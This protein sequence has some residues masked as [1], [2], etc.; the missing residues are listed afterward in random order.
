MQGIAILL[1]PIFSINI[2]MNIC[3]AHPIA[4][5]HVHISCDPKEMPEDQGHQDPDHE[6][7]ANCAGEPPI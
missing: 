7:P 3:D 4:I 1:L 2:M 6:F 5:F